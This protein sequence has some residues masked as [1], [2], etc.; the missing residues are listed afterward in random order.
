MSVSSP[1]SNQCRIIGAGQQE[2]VAGQRAGR[3]GRR[4]P[5]RWT[6]ALGASAGT[7]PAAEELVAGIL[8]VV[9]RE[10]VLRARC[11]R[12]RTGCCRSGRCRSPRTCVPITATVGGLLSGRHRSGP[13]C[14][15]RA[16]R[17]APRG[18]PRRPSRRGCR[19]AAGGNPGGG[20]RPPAHRGEHSAAVLAGVHV[21]VEIDVG[22]ASGIRDDDRRR[23]LVEGRSRTDK[24]SP[25]RW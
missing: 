18:R 3:D 19:S 2:V 25:A 5:C 20:R 15:A 16:G 21:P 9:E 14:T 7:V 11:A 10:V 12:T 17:R 1:S 4:S 8:R 24:T 13:P 23:D 6:S 22:D